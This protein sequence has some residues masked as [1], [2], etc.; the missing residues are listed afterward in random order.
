MKYWGALFV[1]S[2]I[3]PVGITV[4]LG[5]RMALPLFVAL[6]LGDWVRYSWRFAALYAA[7]CWEFLH[8]LFDQAV[9]V[10]WYPSALFG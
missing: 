3:F 4:V 6:Y 10:L 8:L 5:Q 1:S 9:H 2:L 7:A